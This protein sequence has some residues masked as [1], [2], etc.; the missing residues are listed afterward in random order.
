MFRV[1]YSGL[2][3]SQSVPH[4]S[5]TK[6]TALYYT[7]R[8]CDNV[9]AISPWS[10]HR[11]VASSTGKRPHAL[12]NI[13]NVE[14][15]NRTWPESIKAETLGRVQGIIFDVDGTLYDQSALRWRMVS[16][17]ASA[18]WS[19]P[20]EGVR[21][22]RALQAYRQ[23]HE[24]LRNKF[25]SPDLQLAAAAAK[26]RYPVAEVRSTVDQWFERTPLD[27]LPRCTYSGIPKFLHLLSELRISCGVFS[28]Y[29]A[30]AK[31]SAMGLEGFFSHVL[32]AAEVGR[33][34]PDPIGIL[35]VAREMGLA[36][37]G[38]L[39]VGDRTIDLE[40]AAKAGMQ[41]LLIQGGN[42]YSILYRRFASRSR[43]QAS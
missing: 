24:E 9:L 2:G 37:E 7:T 42:S 34:K 15:V 25:F 28:D 41:G 32:C 26:C 8:G 35:T 3:A 20:I 14:V 1:A 38:T 36:P 18:H 39:C 29:P 6:T 43:Q 13:N 19:A 11:Q 4:Q 31:L 40:A 5:R 33:L 16:R 17:I 27:L 10:P 12:E 21:V 22:I 23:A 30:E